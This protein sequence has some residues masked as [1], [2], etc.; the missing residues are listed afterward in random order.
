MAGYALAD[1]IVIPS[2]H[3]KE[4]FRRDPTAYA[5]L[6]TNPYGVDLEMFPTAQRRNPDKEFTLLF[7]GTWTLRKGCDLLMSAIAR[8]PGVRLVHVGSI[9]SDLAFPIDDP[10]LCP[11]RSRAADRTR[12]DSTLRLTHLCWP[13]G[14]MAS[15]VV[16]AQA[17]ASGFR[18]SAPIVPAG[19]PRAHAGFGQA[20][21]SYPRRFVLRWLPLLPN[22]ATVY[23]TGE[24]F[25]PLT[26][27]DRETLSWAAYGRRYAEQIAAHFGQSRLR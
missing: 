22:C 11:Y 17:L 7:V 15:A 3:V 18:S 19:R 20:H 26:D 13:R 6:F 12:D 10:S 21:K 16:L 25:P 24:R 2:L 5:K 1:R 9:G 27:A 14:R 23:K 4:S 8:T